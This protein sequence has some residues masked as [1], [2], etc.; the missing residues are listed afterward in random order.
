M[1]VELAEER[2]A[3]PTEVGG[4]ATIGLDQ[5]RMERNREEVQLRDAEEEGRWRGS[6]LSW[7]SRTIRM[8]THCIKAK[9]FI[10]G[11]SLYSI[12]RSH[13]E[14]RRLVLDGTRATT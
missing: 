4:G 11:F 2:D 13:D 5:R 1:G 6:S 9:Q 7:E 14:V 10:F 12:F 3:V 8:R